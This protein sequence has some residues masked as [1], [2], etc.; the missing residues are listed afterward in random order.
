[1]TIACLNTPVIKTPVNLPRPRGRPSSERWN[2]W[3]KGA[4]KILAIKEYSNPLDI[5]WTFLRHENK[6]EL[7][8]KWKPLHIRKTP[9]PF[10]C[11][12][13]KLECCNFPTE[14]GGGSC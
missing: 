13:I 14:Q 8:K 11:P 10:E 9:P 4:F 6:F 12:R 2:G 3:W 7:Q 1:M 5:R